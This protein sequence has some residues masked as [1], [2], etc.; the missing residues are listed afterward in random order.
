MYHYLDPSRSQAVI[1]QVMGRACAEV[2]VSD[3]W[4]A[5][6]KAPAQTRQLCLAHQIR[7]L[8]GLLEQQPRLRWARD[9]QGLLREAIHLGKRRTQLTVRGYQRR[10]SELER[11]LAALV[12]RRVRTPAAQT[13]VKCYRKHQAHLL[14]FLHDPRVPAHNNDCERSLRS[15]VVHR[16]VSGGFRSRWGAQAYADLA[17]V[18]DTAKLRGQAVFPT[19]VALMVPP[20]LPLIQAQTGE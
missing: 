6:L 7:N 18:I 13:L 16:K 14:M 15:V 12:T 2:W 19:L 11:R 9:L 4:S 3:C 10:V 5:Q 17:S 1:Q 8:Q 20:V